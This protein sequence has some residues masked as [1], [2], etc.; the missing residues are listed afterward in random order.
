[1]NLQPGHLVGVSVNVI[2]A[3]SQGPSVEY[4]RCL[5]YY[6]T[7]SNWSH[8][9]ICSPVARQLA[10]TWQAVCT[11]IVLRELKCYHPS[12]KLIGP[13]STELKHI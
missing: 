7:W 12:M 3:T 11:R 10:L 1:V 9:E 8:P 5:H 13:P 6:N 2:L 4:L